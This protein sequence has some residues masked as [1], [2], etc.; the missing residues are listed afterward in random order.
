MMLVKELGHLLLV[1]IQSECD[2]VLLS[3]SIPYR[4]DG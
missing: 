2:S 1:L 4:D 3:L